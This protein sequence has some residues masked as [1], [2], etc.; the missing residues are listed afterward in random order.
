MEIRDYSEKFAKEKDR[1][2]K[3]SS[4]V[5]ENYKKNLEDL[6][7]T[8]KSIQDKR[9]QNHEK[10]IAK[11]EQDNRSSIEEH[12]DKTSRALNRKKEEFANNLEDTK[13]NFY[14]ESDVYRREMKRKL[15]SAQDAYKEDL[16]NFK[17]VMTQRE[18]GQLS[19][20]DETKGKM[21]DFMNKKERNL[22]NNFEDKMEKS[23]DDY[24]YMK[25]KLTDNYH[26]QTA[27]QLKEHVDDRNNLLTDNK[28]KIK[29]MRVANT[30]KLNEQDSL[31]S[32]K[33]QKQD[34]NFSRG[35]EQ[36]M[37]SFGK[38]LEN[39]KE[40]SQD[41]K[42]KYS[43]D[44][45][46]T[47]R[48]IIR[49]NSVNRNSLDKEI[50]EVNKQ[51]NISEESTR[52]RID[53][54]TKVADDRIKNFKLVLDDNNQ[55]YSKRL[56]IMNDKTS[57]RIAELKYDF[58]VELSDQEDLSNQALRQKE[59]DG[60]SDLSSAQLVYRNQEKNTKD[61]NQE[62][63]DIKDYKYKQAV[64]GL[65]NQ[66][67]HAIETQDKSHA[68]SME[69]LSKDL[70]RDKTEF[71]EKG[72]REFQGMTEEQRRNYKRN[73]QK[74]E[75][76][77]NQKIQ[78]QDEITEKMARHYENKIAGMEKKFIDEI[79]STRNLF[80]AKSEMDRKDTKNFL[81]K[82]EQDYFTKLM[83]IKSLF[84]NKMAKDKI[85]R[86]SELNKFISR[87]EDKIK[88][89]TRDHEVEM[90]QYKNQTEAKY[91]ALQSQSFLKEQNLTGQLE[92]KVNKLKV[93]Y[94]KDNRVE[95]SES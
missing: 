65:K 95:P 2:Q 80:E 70:N 55:K 60:R 59:R 29:E 20:M 17:D 45:A 30:N 49:D 41:D 66:F 48:N 10:S 40:I 25:Q 9:A 87:Y 69:G 88:T 57:D 46:E 53:H 24:K 44:T 23:N 1:F 84:H 62:I 51:R 67:G 68:M 27:D 61:L 64:S 50:A 36:M 78:G 92:E 3:A 8:H 83:D 21:I 13:S 56:D 12:A 54:A 81:Q 86:E 73:L 82:K 93:A 90:M 22:V 42:Q 32:D 58:N 19:G 75:I 33:L 16:S 77:F 26:D 7:N 35:R 34:V 37:D 4:E 31:Y 71:I 43:N 76:K 79:R 18:K 74:T 89:L 39:A 5:R 6:E 15:A 72:K 28:N 47:I 38:Q 11:I 63:H 85:A 14:K 94:A 91:K 52:D